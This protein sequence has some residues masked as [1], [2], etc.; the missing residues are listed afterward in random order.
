MLAAT[1]EISAAHGPDGLA[2]ARL[3]ASHDIEARLNL[4]LALTLT[5]TLALTLT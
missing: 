4:S 3:L 5:L 1:L 2:S